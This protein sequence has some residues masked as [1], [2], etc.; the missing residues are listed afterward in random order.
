MSMSRC[1]SPPIW[2]SPIGPRSLVNQTEQ[3]APHL[4][5]FPRVTVIDP[6]HPLCGQTLQ[7]VRDSSPRGKEN[8]TLRLPNG[9]HRSI[10]RRATN[11]ERNTP[12]PKGRFEL[13]RISVRTMLPLA[14]FIRSR[15]RNSEEK[16]HVRSADT[17][18][19]AVSAHQ[20]QSIA[21]RPL[22]PTPPEHPP[23]DRPALGQGSAE[24]TAG[25][26]GGAR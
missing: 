16:H 22:E 24:D 11:L 25:K 19:D 14:T 17:R 7:M 13:S 5:R 10:P 3:N 8:L 2:P 15:L 6:A 21:A 26:S 4:D 9:Q 23:A 18:Q 20:E 12:S 1:W